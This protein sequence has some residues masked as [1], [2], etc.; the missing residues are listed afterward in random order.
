MNTLKNNCI[1][2]IYVNNINIEKIPK[3]LITVH[4]NKSIRMKSIIKSIISKKFKWSKY[5]MIIINII[6]K[7]KITKLMIYIIHDNFPRFTMYEYH[8][9]DIA[10]YNIIN[11][12]IN[13]NC[14]L[15]YKKILNLINNSCTTLNVESYIFGEY[16]KKDN[17]YDDLIIVSHPYQTSEKIVHYINLDYLC[18]K[19]KFVDINSKD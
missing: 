3:S 2:S 18:I 7:E 11:M 17:R 10:P 8:I 14:L 13:S 16:S 12:G 4:D 15:G 5:K 9:S 1:K 6:N 19:L